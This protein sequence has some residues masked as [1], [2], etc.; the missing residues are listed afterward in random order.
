ML[1]KLF[2]KGISIIKAVVV[3]VISIC[4]MEV[5]FLEKVSIKIA[6]V[7]LVEFSFRRSSISLL[8]SSIQYEKIHQK[9]KEN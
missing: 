7:N 4:N 6:G 8:E 5:H 3:V 2:K 9:R 1:F